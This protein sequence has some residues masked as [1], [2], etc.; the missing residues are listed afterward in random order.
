M[1]LYLLDT[2]IVS[3][4]VKG[5]SPAARSRL[6]AVPGPSVVVSVITEAE[7]RYGVAKRGEPAVL[8]KAVDGFL[9]RVR[10][11]PWSRDAAQAYARMRVRR[12][13]V[14]MPLGPMDMLI[15]AQAKAAGAVLVSSDAAFGSFPDGLQLEDWSK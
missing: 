4:L 3:Y 13:A 5:N 11:L 15:A 2:N 1:T 6:M 14:G 7:L 12:E 10:V 8:K 9:A